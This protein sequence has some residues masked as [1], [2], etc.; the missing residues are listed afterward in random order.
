MTISFEF[1]VLHDKFTEHTD[2]T[3]TGSP[4]WSVLYHTW[5]VSTKNIVPQLTIDSIMGVDV[6]QTKTQIIAF[7]TQ[8]PI[9]CIQMI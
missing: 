6:V 9:C 3:E 2:F 4:M 1:N 7:D 8:Q 5:A